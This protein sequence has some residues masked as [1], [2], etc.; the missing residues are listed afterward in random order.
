MGYLKVWHNKVV[1]VTVWPLEGVKI[2][3]VR[4]VNQKN[5]LKMY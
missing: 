1:A 5:Q 3:S 2:T 4:F